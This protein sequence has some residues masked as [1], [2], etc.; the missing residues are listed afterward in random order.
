MAER[1][2]GFGIAALV[3]LFDQLTKWLITGPLGIN[4]IGDQL[5]L[6]RSSTHLHPELRDFAWACSRLQGL[7]ASGLIVVT[8]AI[9]VGVAWWIG[10]E[11]L[12]PTRPAGA[13][14]RRRRL[15]IS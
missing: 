7:L 4:Q 2:Y 1:K 6:C 15:E 14:P 3:F 11:K 5:E 9:A 12:A 13:G 8:G 10:S